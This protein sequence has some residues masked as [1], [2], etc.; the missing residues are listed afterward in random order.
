MEI[1]AMPGIFTWDFYGPGSRLYLES[2]QTNYARLLI[3]GRQERKWMDERLEQRLLAVDFSSSAVNRTLQSA[4]EDESGQEDREEKEAIGRMRGKYDL[5]LPQMSPSVFPTHGLSQ[6][7]FRDW[8]QA[9]ATQS[10]YVA[11]ALEALEKA[12]QKQRPLAKKYFELASEAEQ[13][14]VHA[15]TQILT[16]VVEHVP[17]EVLVS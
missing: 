6:T 10:E 14:R 17:D 2:A 12:R 4:G 16:Y 3:R 8:M 9:Y 11:R 7:L 15:S 1:E 5:L 13:I